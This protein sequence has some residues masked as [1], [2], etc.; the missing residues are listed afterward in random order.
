MAIHI[1]S[2]L[3]FCWCH[4]KLLSED[5]VSIAGTHRFHQL[6]AAEGLTHK[7]Q[8]NSI[9]QKSGI[10]KSAGTDLAMLKKLPTKSQ[11]KMTSFFFRLNLQTISNNLPNSL[12]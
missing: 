3:R 7:L 4:K 1:E 5:A 2:T 10:T 11:Q 6:I 8:C 9:I 12:T